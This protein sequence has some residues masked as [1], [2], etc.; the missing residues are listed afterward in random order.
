MMSAQAGI[1]PLPCDG[2]G[3][4]ASS[5]HIAWRLRRLELTTRYRPIHVQ[6]VFLGA[7]SPVRDEEFL[8]GVQGNFQGEAG[9]LLQALHIESSGRAVEAVLAEFQR[10]GFL[11]T[12][13]LEC[14]GERGIMVT[15]SLKRK[16]PSALKRLRTSL[17]PKKLVVVS[18]AMA[19]MIGDLKAAQIGAELVLDG[20]TPFVLN[21]TGSVT[22]LRSRL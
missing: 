11:L 8:Y 9:E 6:A 10:K 12:H 13:V 17:R 21:D 16:L 1:Q 19:P 2:C 14:A 20:D 22:R 5:A 15:D 18:A 7:Q 3:E 4:L